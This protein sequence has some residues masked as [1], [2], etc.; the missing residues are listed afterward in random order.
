MIEPLKD[1]IDSIF[2]DVKS[3]NDQVSLELFRDDGHGE[4]A[5]KTD[6][7]NK[8][9][10]LVTAL[11]VENELIKE[12]LDDFDLYGDYLNQFRR[13]KVSLDRKSRTE[14]VEANRKPAPSDLLNE[15]AS[16][17]TLTESRK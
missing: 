14:F 16:A 1:P 15:T 8:E 7:I 3:S 12:D 17:K 4:I 2:E 9:H 10:V 11:M 13:H 6:L 5:L